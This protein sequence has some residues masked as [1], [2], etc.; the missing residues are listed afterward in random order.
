M[1][2]VVLRFQY[3]MVYSSYKAIL[4]VCQAA[5]FFHCERKPSL[6][7]ADLFGRRFFVLCSFIFLQAND[8]LYI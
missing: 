8:F 2:H 4:H 5:I 6:C 7:W 3:K 1:P